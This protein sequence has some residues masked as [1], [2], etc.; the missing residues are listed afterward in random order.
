MRAL[1]LDNPFNTLESVET[2]Q[3]RLD[4]SRQSYIRAFMDAM[5][6][7]SRL[8]Q[9]DGEFREVWK[10]SQ[11]PDDFEAQRTR[12]RLRDQYSAVTLEVVNASTELQQLLSAAGFRLAS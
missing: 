9:D 11:T 4:L 6:A 3:I 1:T 8:A 12:Y 2:K 5:K 10:K 7:V